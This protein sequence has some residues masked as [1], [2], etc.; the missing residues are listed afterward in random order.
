MTD[1]AAAPTITV[2]AIQMEP[3]IGESERNIARSLDMT[4]RAADKGAT[5]LVLPELTRWLQRAD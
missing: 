5:L 4:A 1:G 2:A 3:R